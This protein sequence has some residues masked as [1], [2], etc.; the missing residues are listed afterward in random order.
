MG[1]TQHLRIGEPVIEIRLRRSGQ[2]RRFVLRVPNTGPDAVLSLP[3]HA[4]RTAALDFVAANEAWLRE[5]LAARGQQILAAHGAELPFQG[6]TLRIEALGRPG[7]LAAERGI[8]RVP[9]EFRHVP[10]KVKGFLREAARERLVARVLYH[11]GRL[12]RQPGRITLRDTRARWGSCTSEGHLMFSWR[13]VM[14]PQEVLDYVVAHEVAHL[15]EMNHSKRF[16]SLVAELRPDHEDQ[17][18]WLRHNGAKLH[19]YAFSIA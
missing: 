15:V 4:S 5:K 2:A 11:A 10:G 14:A 18:H 9:G 12:D 1:V 17:R 19:H 7:R 6:E 13:L 16:W 3:R 8:L